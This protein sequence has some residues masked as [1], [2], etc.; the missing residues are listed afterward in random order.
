[1]ALA[2]PIL[3]S[4]FG[5]FEAAYPRYAELG[6]T[7]HAHNSYVQLAAEAGLPATL[8]LFVGLAASLAA[9]TAPLKRK[10][11]VIVMAEGVGAVPLQSPFRADEESLPDEVF[12]LR[13]LC[14]GLVAGVVGHMGHN[15]FDSDLYIPS[16]SVALA[17]TI[18]IGMGAAPILRAR[19]QAM[20]DAETKSTSPMAKWKQP[21]AYTAILF[22]CAWGTMTALGRMRTLDGLSTK[23]GRS[24]AEQSFQQ[25]ASYDRLNPDPALNL[26]SLLAQAGDAAGAE[27]WYR[28]AIHRADVGKTRYRFGKFLVA[29]GR[30]QDAISEFEAAR[31][32][33]PHNLSNLLALAEA[34]TATG[35]PDQ[36]N[37]VYQAMA[38]LYERPFD[39]IRAMPELVNW[40]IGEAMVRLAQSKADNDPTQQR[41]LLES[42]VRVLDS[43]WRTRNNELVQQ[44]MRPDLLINAAKSLQQALDALAAIEK[45]A[46]KT[47]D[48]AAKVSRREELTK[49]IESYG[50]QAS[51]A[52]GE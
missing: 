26:A 28:D 39:R 46:G 9:M 49:E 6:Y 19:M 24:A 18:G 5:A 16:N 23:D 10:S 36:A 17:V 14:C 40:E 22:M 25:A 35:H 43:F 29:Q 34:Q 48:A 12:D 33:D 21:V 45:A 51:K 1:M 13:L 42:G 15:L 38:D 41:Q 27:K 50:Q 20:E 3:G 31:R 30:S 4:G 7:Q 47:E 52:A 32:A 37:L 2:K 8:L 44:R 11:Q